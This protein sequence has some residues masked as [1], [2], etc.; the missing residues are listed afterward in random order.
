MKNNIS[1]ISASI[2]LFTAMFLLPIVTFAQNNVYGIN[3]EKKTLQSIVNIVVEYF[4]VGV[5]FIIGLAFITFVWNVYRYFFMETEK[6]KEAGM[7]VLFSTIG[8]FVILSIWGLVALLTNTFNLEKSQPLWPF[9]QPKSG[10]NIGN[11]F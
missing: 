2:G 7:Y 4:K 6:R 11:K 5:Y 3:P 9:S 8:F 10:P 1:K